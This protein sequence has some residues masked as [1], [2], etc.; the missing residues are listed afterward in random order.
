LL[1][2]CEYLIFFLLLFFSTIWNVEGLISC[3][4]FARR[5]MHH[6]HQQSGYRP[7]GATWVNSSHGHMPPN[8]VQGGHEA[9]GTPLYIARAMADGR[10][11]TPGKLHTG[12]QSLYIPYGG[13]EQEKKEYQV[14]THPQQAELT[15]VPASNGTVPTGALQGGWMQNSSGEPLFIGRANHAGGLCPGKV[16]ASHGCMYL[17]YGGQEIRITNYEVLCQRA[18]L[19]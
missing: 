1:R 17:S 6:H 19:F 8:A 5:K 3:V 15:W 7:C 11:L 16:V 2:M 9:N 18:I 12:Y 13:K 4:Q 10:D 14:L